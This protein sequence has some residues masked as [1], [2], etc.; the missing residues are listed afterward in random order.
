MCLKVR[1]RKER[2]PGPRTCRSGTC[3]ESVCQGV[4]AWQA[5]R[6]VCNLAS[7]SALLCGILVWW[8]AWMLG[9]IRQPGRVH[10]MAAASGCERSTKSGTV[11]NRS[12][13]FL[14]GPLPRHLFIRD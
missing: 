5:I 13:A 4:V 10:C 7:C 2:P 12:N 3:E 8:Y 9:S 11:I 1:R 14:R 6:C